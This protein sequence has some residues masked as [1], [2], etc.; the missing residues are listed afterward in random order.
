MDAFA[1]SLA[2]GLRSTFRYG[3]VW[4]RL[5]NFGPLYGAKGVGK[6]KEHLEDALSKGATLHYGGEDSSYGPNFFPATVVKGGKEGMKFMTE[7]T[8]GPLAFL[9]PFETEE[10]VIRMANNSVNGEAPV[11]LASYLYTENM[12]RCW[13]VSEALKVGMVGV[14]VGLVSAAEG[15]FGGVFQSGLGR[16]GGLAA[17]D[18]FLDVKSITIGIES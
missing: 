7:E 4:D 8:F 11:G 12:S 15:P 2:E 6:V 17:L 10:E 13:K 5:T 1:D 18:E 14:R 3:S 9:I 16:E